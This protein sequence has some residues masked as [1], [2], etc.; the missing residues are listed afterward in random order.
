MASHLAHL[1]SNKLV[2]PPKWLVSNEIYEAQIGS[3]AYGCSSDTSDMDIIGI[4]IPH[5]EDIFPHLRGEIPDFGTQKQRFGEWEKQHVKNPDALGGYG[6]E[7]DFKIYNIIKFFHLGMQCNANFI[8]ALFVPRTCLL[9]CNSVGEIIREN[10]K[11]FLSKKAWHSFKGY[12]YGQMSDIKKNKTKNSEKRKHLIAQFG[13]DVK[14]AY[15]VVRLLD[16]V[17]QI[18]TLGDLD[19]QRSR[20]QMKAIRA[21]EWTLNEISEYFTMRE[22]ELEKVYAESKLP[23]YPDEEGIKRVLLQCL[24]HHYGSLAECLNTG[25]EL[26]KDLTEIEN[27][28]A[29]IR[30]NI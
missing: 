28:V 14:F 18:L 1:V 11:I 24:E 27:I 20:E 13:Y 19:I 26:T 6:R 21:G 10:R 22:K 4:C 8:D 17:D 23:Y 12:A 29:R 15:H 25:Y 3:V 30:K 9:Y 16:E 2:D 7:Y 5:K